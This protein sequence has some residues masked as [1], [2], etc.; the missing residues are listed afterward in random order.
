M[1]PDVDDMQEPSKAFCCVSK[2]EGAVQRDYPL[3]DGIPHHRQNPPQ[4]GKGEEPVNGL[5]MHYSAKTC[6]MVFGV[7][8]FLYMLC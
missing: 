7:S 6:S 4:G 1:G 5:P 3:D 8:G 2:R